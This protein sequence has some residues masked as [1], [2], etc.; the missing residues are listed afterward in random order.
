MMKNQSIKRNVIGALLL[1]AITL[2]ACSFLWGEHPGYGSQ[3]TWTPQPQMTDEPYHVEVENVS[4]FGD[5]TVVAIFGSQDLE[6]TAPIQMFNLT[7]EDVYDVSALTRGP[8]STW[9]RPFMTEDKQLFFQIGDMLYK[10]S[11]GGGVSSIEVPFNDED[12]IFC[13]WSWQGAAGLR[14]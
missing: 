3:A 7:T 11:P 1:L 13:N 9:S 4:Y 14:Q 10:L 8:I 6:D 5:D 12:P 2:Q